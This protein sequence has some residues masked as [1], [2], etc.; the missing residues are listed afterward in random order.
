MGTPP[1]RVTPYLRTPPAAFSIIEEER[2]KAAITKKKGDQP[3]LSNPFPAT[4]YRIKRP[5]L[6]QASSNRTHVSRQEFPR[7]ATNPK[8]PAGPR[9]QTTPLGRPGQ[10]RPGP[11][12]H[13][14]W[15]TRP[16]DP[17]NVSASVSSP[18]R[19]DR[20]ALWPRSDNLTLQVVFRR[21]PEA[22]ID[23][24]PIS[25]RRQDPTLQ[26]VI[27][28]PQAPDC[29]YLGVSRLLK[30]DWGLAF[31]T[32]A[33]RPSNRGVKEETS[34]TRMIE[35]S[36]EDGVRPLNQGQKPR[37]RRCEMRPTRSNLGHPGPTLNAAIPRIA[38]LILGSFPAQGTARILIQRPR[39]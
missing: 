4:P 16:P 9:H 3:H 30:D 20:H 32:L 2:A 11:S 17:I 19:P 38:W 31:E 22:P 21:S 6:P 37:P 12:T 13:P 10:V 8:K 28:L 24:L 33:P 34:A 29:R 18:T 39:L 27:Q 7:P 35:I 1:G 15:I 25:H 36:K 26:N 23:L 14:T 5:D